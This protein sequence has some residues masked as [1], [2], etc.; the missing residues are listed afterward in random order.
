MMVTALIL[1]GLAPVAGCGWAE[2]PP[3][4]Q[5]ELF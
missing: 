3:G 1:A 2:W 4:W 5:W